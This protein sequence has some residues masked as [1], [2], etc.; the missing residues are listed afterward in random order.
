MRTFRGKKVIGWKVILGPGKQELEDE[1]NKLMD[2][3]EFVDCQY[4]TCTGSMSPSEYSALVLLGE[5]DG[6]D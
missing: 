5:K 2:K 4:S 1:L 6:K 3:Y